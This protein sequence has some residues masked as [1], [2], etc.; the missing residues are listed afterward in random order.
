MVLVILYKT[1]G[2]FLHFTSKIV[3]LSLDLLSNIILVGV[4]TTLNRAGVSFHFIFKAFSILKLPDN[5]LLI[6]KIKSANISL[7]R[8][9]ILHLLLLIMK[10]NYQ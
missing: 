10:V 7:Q 5:P 4:F 8:K 1:P 3:K 9:K 6:Q 2:A